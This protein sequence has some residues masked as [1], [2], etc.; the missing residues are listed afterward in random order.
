MLPELKA[1]VLAQVVAG[2][3]QVFTDPKASPTGFPFKVVRVA[4]TLSEPEVFESR[5]RIC[6]IGMLREAFAGED[7]A[8][9]WRCPA[10]PETHYL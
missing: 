8:V 10:E 4:G 5:D 6:D 2:D 1:Q 7:G 9:G 3:V